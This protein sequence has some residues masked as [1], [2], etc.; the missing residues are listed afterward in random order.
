MSARRAPRRRFTLIALGLGALACAGA[1]LGLGWHLVPAWLT[2]WSLVAFA[3]CGYDKLRARAGGGRVPESV[4]HGVA[5]VG[6]AAG[7]WAGMIL[8]RHKTRKP[9]FRIVLL[10]ASAIQIAAVVWLLR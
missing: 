1:V 4:L 3:L 9:V 5:L 10:V 2:A 8:F 6:G 7:S